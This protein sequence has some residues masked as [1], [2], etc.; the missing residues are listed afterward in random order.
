MKK[1]CQYQLLTGMENNWNSPVLLVEMQKGTATLENSFAVSYK[2][3]H[4][5]TT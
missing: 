3:K 4:T 5:L 1:E 2:A